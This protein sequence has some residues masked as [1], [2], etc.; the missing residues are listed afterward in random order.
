MLYSLVPFTFQGVLGLEGMLATPIVD[1]SGVGNAM[2]QMVGG[3]GI[4]TS[5]MI[6]LMILALMLAIMTA[7]AGSSRTLYQGSVD[8]WLPR[9][10]SHVNPHGAPTAAMWTDLVFNLFLLAIAAADATSYFFILA[11]SNCGYIIF[12]FLNLNAGWIHRIDNGHIPRPWKAPTI[13]IAAGCVLSFVNAMFMGAGAK[14]WNPWAL[15][16][17]IIAAALIIP[18]FWFRHYVQDGGKFPPHMLDDLGLN[19]SDLA[20]RK[21]GIL[22][23]LTLAG[24]VAV[25]L[26]A[27]WIF[28]I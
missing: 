6:M 21:A 25:V 17:G 9:Y 2:A 28:V 3:T 13:F 20:V 5:I 15:W 4:I 11:V 12:N 18:V 14:V 23:Y 10:L 1:G 26:L 7:M 22:P 19:Q 16:A 8:G 27:N 24:G